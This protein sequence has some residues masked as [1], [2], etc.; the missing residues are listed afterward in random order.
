MLLCTAVYCCVLK[1]SCHKVLKSDCVIVIV[2]CT[3]PL[4]LSLPKSLN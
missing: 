2:F 4:D 1:V 3:A